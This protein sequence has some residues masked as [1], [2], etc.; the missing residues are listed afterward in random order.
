M[1]ERAFQTYLLVDTKTQTLSFIKDGNVAKT[2]PISTSKFGIGAV[3]DSFKTPLGVHRVAEKYG[4]G[5]PAGRI[6]RS[7]KDTGMDW[8][9]KS[10]EENLILTRILRLAGLEPGVNQG[11]DVDSFERYIYIH[12]TNLENSIGKPASHGCV[13][14]KNQDIIELYAQVPENTV[15]VIA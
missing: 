3:K 4:E 8:D 14:M 5:C 9:G 2:Y 10:L 1:K 13:L 6:F 11:G 15:V 7:R 12:G